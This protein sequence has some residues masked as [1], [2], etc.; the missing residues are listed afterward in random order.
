MRIRSM[1]GA[2]GKES[3]ASVVEMMPGIG[4]DRAVEGMV[5]LAVLSCSG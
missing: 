5:S 3:I 2:A 1:S 4:S